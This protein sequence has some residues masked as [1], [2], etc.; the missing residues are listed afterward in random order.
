MSDILDRAIAAFVNR[1]VASLEVQEW[2]DG[3]GN[4]T[5]VYFKTPNAAVVSNVTRKAKDGVERAAMIVIAMA[6][7][8]KGERLFGD[9]HLHDFMT[10][11]DPFVTSR[12]A[13]AILKDARI[14]DQSAEKN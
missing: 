1:P 6:T 7:D 12:I 3:D 10:S 11:I 9:G 13:A 8:E 5:V 2:K 4:P 14:D